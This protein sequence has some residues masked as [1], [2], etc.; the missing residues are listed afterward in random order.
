MTTQEINFQSATN[1]TL[2]HIFEKIENITFPPI[3]KR[4]QN[5]PLH[6]PFTGIWAVRGNQIIGLILADKNPSGSSEVFSFLVIPKERNKKIGKQLLKLLEN[7]LKNQGVSRLQLRYRSDWGSLPVIQK[8]L[9]SNNWET[10][11]LIRVIAE[12]D[13]K[14][15]TNTPWPTMKLSTD[16]S[17]FNWKDLTGNDRKQIDR[18]MMGQK[19]P[20]EFNPYQHEDKIFLPA[21]FGLRHKSEIIGWNIVYSLSD[22]TKEYNNLFIVE[23]FRKLGHAITLIHK[24]TEE[25][26]K[27]NIPKATW[28]I[29]ADNKATLKIVNYITVDHLSKHVEVWIS[30]KR[31]G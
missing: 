23:E 14:Q 1:I 10:P 27:L 24:S 6:E 29:N 13:I 3:R 7:S 17:L 20:S 25:Q 18:M 8:M 30:G 9:K 2:N 28:L 11:Q 31:L 15:F 22:D 5:I 16:Y 19:V 4:M 12:I 26:Y 21:S